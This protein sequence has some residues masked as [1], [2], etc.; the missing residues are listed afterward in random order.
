MLIIVSISL[1]YVRTGVKERGKLDKS[2]FL[3]RDRLMTALSNKIIQALM[4]SI[5]STLHPVFNKYEQSDG[6]GEAG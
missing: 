4:K 3:E 6:F 2:R 1:E 5:S